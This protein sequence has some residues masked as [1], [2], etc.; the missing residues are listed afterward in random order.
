MYEQRLRIIAK[1]APSLAETIR[2]RGGF[3]LQTEVGD[4]EAIDPHMKL[5]VRCGNGRFIATACNVAHFV[6]IVD[7][8]DMDYVRDVAILAS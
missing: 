8:S 7:A 1:V 5:L 3:V 6:A 2:N 4:I